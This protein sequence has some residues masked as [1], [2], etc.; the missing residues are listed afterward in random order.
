MFDETMYQRAF[1]IF[2]ILAALALVGIAGWGQYW[3]TWIVS[4]V[5][6][7]ALWVA[8]LVVMDRH[9]KNQTSF[10]E[11]NVTSDRFEGQMVQQPVTTTHKQLDMVRGLLTQMIV[12]LV[13]LSSLMLIKCVFLLVIGATGRPSDTYQMVFYQVFCIVPD[14]ALTGLFMTSGTMDLFALEQYEPIASHARDVEAAGEASKASGLRDSRDEVAASES[15][16]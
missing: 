2:F 8:S 9:R 14:L 3:Y 4:L 1:V 6:F 16:A 12:L 5:F 10:P 15:T 7:F 11:G 13:V